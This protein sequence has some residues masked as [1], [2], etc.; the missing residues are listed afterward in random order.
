MNCSRSDSSS[1]SKNARAFVTDSSVSSMMFFPPTVTARTSG[2]RRFPWQTGHATSLITALISSFAH[3]PPSAKRRFRFGITPS[4]GARN[5][6][7]LPPVVIRCRHSGSSFVPYRNRSSCCRSIYHQR[8]RFIPEFSRNLF[9][10][11][12]IINPDFFFSLH[13]LSQCRKSP[14][15]TGHFVPFSLKITGQSTHTYSSDTQEIN[16]FYRLF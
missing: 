1:S 12:D 13:F 8:R 14:V 15:I 11:I 16:V 5:P 7:L 6:S 4:N 3:S 10:F 9:L 2:F